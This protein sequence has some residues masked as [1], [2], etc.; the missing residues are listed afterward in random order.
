[1][2]NKTSM[3]GDEGTSMREF[4]LLLLSGAVDSHTTFP[5][6]W[7]WMMRVCASSRMQKMG[8]AVN[9]AKSSQH[10]TISQHP[11]SA[12]TQ[13]PNSFSLTTGIKIRWKVLKIT[14]VFLIL[15]VAFVVL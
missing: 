2:S 3:E 7:K 10:G 12:S 6:P 9:R 15:K 13:F 14:P 1:M 11:G 4:F 5:V 8:Q